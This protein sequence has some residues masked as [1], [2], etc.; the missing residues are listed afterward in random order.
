MGALFA[1]TFVDG[2]K[3]NVEGKNARLGV[4][5]PNFD[6]LW[7]DDRQRASDCLLIGGDGVVLS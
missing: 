5:L 4:P 1:Q 6:L 3:M 2:G 7:A